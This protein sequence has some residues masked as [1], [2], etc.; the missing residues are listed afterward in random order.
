MESLI[1]HEDGIAS[2]DFTVET[3]VE[4]PPLPSLAIQRCAR[5][6][7]LMDSNIVRDGI[8]SEQIATTSVEDATN[9][10][11]DTVI[12]LDNHGVPQPLPKLAPIFLRPSQSKDVDSK[13]KKATKRRSKPQSKKARLDLTARK[14]T[15]V[16][17]QEEVVSLLTDAE[18]VVTYSP[19]STKRCQSPLRSSQKRSRSPSPKSP[20]SSPKKSSS[21]PSSLLHMVSR[22]PVK[23]TKTRPTPVIQQDFAPFSRLVHVQQFADESFD[24]LKSVAIRP[25][26]DVDNTV[27]PHH[28][29]SYSCLLSTSTGHKHH[30]KH[31]LSRPAMLEYLQSLKKQH[32]GFDIHGLFQRYSSCTRGLYSMECKVVQGSTPRLDGTEKNV[33]SK[34]NRLQRQRKTKHSHQGVEPLTLKCSIPIKQKMDVSGT[35]K[36]VVDYIDAV[37]SSA[38]GKTEQNSTS[39]QISTNSEPID[40]CSPEGPSRIPRLLCNDSNSAHTFS[41]AVNPLLMDQWTDCVYPQK[42]S[43]LLGNMY[44]TTA[45]VSW[46]KEWKEKMQNCSNSEPSKKVSTQPS[47]SSEEHRSRRGI[48]VL[49]TS[50]SDFESPPFTVRQIHPVQVKRKL[51]DGEDDWIVDDSDDEDD[52]PCKAMLISGPTGCGK[53][54]AVYACAKELSFDVIEMNASTLRSRQQVVSRLMEASQSHQ[55]SKSKGGIS[56]YFVVK[57]N[58]DTVPQKKGKRQANTQETSLMSFFQPKK[59]K[60]SDLK[61][62]SEP[63]RTNSV[64]NKASVILLEDVDVLFEEHDKGFWSAV[65]EVLRASR[66]PIILTSNDPTLELACEYLSVSFYAPSVEELSVHLR[67]L[68]LT[69]GLRLPVE[70]SN[71]L[72]KLFKEDMRKCLLTIQM[73]LSDPYGKTVPSQEHIRDAGDGS[74]LP[75]W[76]LSCILN[77]DL[78]VTPSVFPKPESFV[79]LKDC[80]INLCSVLYDEQIKSLIHSCH[81]VSSPSHSE[82]NEPREKRTSKQLKAV[83]WFVDQMSELDTM[84]ASSVEYDPAQISPW[85]KVRPCAS[86]LDDPSDHD[87]STVTETKLLSEIS[88]VCE[89]LS[90]SCLRSEVSP[91]SLGASLST[92]VDIICGTIDSVHSTTKKLHRQSQICSAADP[93][94]SPLHTLSHRQRTVDVLPA[95]GTIFFSEKHRKETKIKRRFSHYFHYSPVDVSLLDS[96]FSPLGSGLDQEKI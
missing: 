61:S 75:C 83:H 60:S 26:V 64:L 88:S 53:T 37:N 71:V 33:K 80:G 25:V 89:A 50:D 44:A 30:G 27:L 59:S 31:V 38:R 18:D 35:P 16:P 85:W 11:K 86:L 76:L 20:Y 67:V 15:G 94:L 45:I 5:E 73:W 46:L 19:G 90:Q 78:S 29:N 55:V 1:S 39:S 7:K 65:Y 3:N 96:L 69:H 23:F 51:P 84:S 66:K 81:D 52:G 77:A 54:A 12:H 95:L 82:P 70:E 24:S 62:T 4:F 49:D 47:P 14:L 56:S 2:K 42:A 57:Q 8:E 92:P 9:A 6:E 13:A 48:S 32:A 93:L 28:G 10:A 21:G 68:S 79:R 17:G 87:G 43:E 36:L 22:S 91:L 41:Q 74:S 72:V 40:L 34:S 58:S 63:Q